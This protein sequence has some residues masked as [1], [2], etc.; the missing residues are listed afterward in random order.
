MCAGILRVAAATLAVTGGPTI[1]LR[2]VFA[3]GGG[4]VLLDG[5]DIRLPRLVQ[6]TARER[7]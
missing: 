7:P 2:V 5:L 4:L 6:A 1:A 3:S